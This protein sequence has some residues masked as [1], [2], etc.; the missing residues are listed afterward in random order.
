M[1]Q[2]IKQKNFDYKITI[3]TLAGLIYD[4]KK[5]QKFCFYYNRQTWGVSR[6]TSSGVPNIRLTLSNG[7]DIHFEDHSYERVFSTLCK[8]V[9]M[10]PNA[11]VYIKS[12]GSISTDESISLLT[13]E[14]TKEAIISFL[15]NTN[16]QRTDPSSLQFALAISSNE[17]IYLES[18]Y[19]GCTE[20]SISEDS[21]YHNISPYFGNPVD[22]LD[23]VRKG[24]LD[25]SLDDW[26]FGR[27]IFSLIPSTDR[28]DIEEEYGIE[29][30]NYSEDEYKQ[31][32]CEGYFESFQPILY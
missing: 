26:Y 25:I 5:D 29:A 13:R 10:Q 17:Y 32:I 8:V 27:V 22:F 7:D 21:S 1:E 6:I 31:L 23:K 4:L 9:S 16:L 2:S 18:S 12:G 14:K 3:S 15:Q 20:E 11:C 30:D 19:V 24:A 28:H